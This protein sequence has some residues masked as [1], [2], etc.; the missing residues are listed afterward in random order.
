MFKS[1][2]RPCLVSGWFVQKDLCY[3]PQYLQVLGD[4]LQPLREQTV[5]RQGQMP[6]PRKM[7]ILLVHMNLHQ[8]SLNQKVFCPPE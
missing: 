6:T 2:V 5:K 8:R 7:L 1:N 3:P 4:V